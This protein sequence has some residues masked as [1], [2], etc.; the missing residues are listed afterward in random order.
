M[1]ML[2]LLQVT[3]VLEDTD[4]RLVKFPLKPS[5]YLVEEINSVSDSILLGP[6]L[7]FAPLNHYS[8]ENRSLVLLAS[9][10]W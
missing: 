10:Q 4:G 7:I 3:F 6:A 8:K 9:Y 1:R 2:F 5:D